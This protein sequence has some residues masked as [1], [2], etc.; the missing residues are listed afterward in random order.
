MVTTQT[1]EAEPQQA[2]QKPD[3]PKNR[4]K[5]QQDKAPAKEADKTKEP[6]KPEKKMGGDG[7]SLEVS[8]EQRQRVIEQYLK[9][10]QEAMK[11]KTNG[12][13]W[14][15]FAS[16]FVETPV[17]KIIKYTRWAFPPY[18]LAEKLAL[19]A[20]NVA[21]KVDPTGA[22]G[23]TRR[24]V[25]EAID[26]TLHLGAMAVVSPVAAPI[27]AGI[28]LKERV[29]GHDITKPKTLPGKMLETAMHIPG[30]I[31]KF[32]WKPGPAMGVIER[33]V[34][35]LKSIVEW[36]AGAAV[37]VVSKIPGFVKGTVD[38]V[39]A[40]VSAP[41]HAID[42]VLKPILGDAKSR[43]TAALLTV[44]MYGVGAYFAPELT[45]TIVA[46]LKSIAFAALRGVGFGV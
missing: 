33:A 6:T 30:D 31:I 38:T 19:G 23:F 40:I 21:E 44:G 26:K 16:N 34:T 35:R 5:D 14:E 46:W 28:Q 27:E 12:I 29:T 39:S 8:P 41:F 20:L 3:Q 43:V 13:F 32:L 10:R 1:P 4:L 11:G 15:R 24:K 45:A 37:A 2:E 9:E 17:R 7:A 36:T 22:I 42:A 25:K 18:L